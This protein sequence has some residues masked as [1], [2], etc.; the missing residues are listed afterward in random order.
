MSERERQWL[1]AA[2]KFAAEMDPSLTLAAARARITT[3][4]A[5]AAVIRFPADAPVIC[6]TDGL[7]ADEITPRLSKAID[8]VRAADHCAIALGITLPVGSVD[9][10]PLPTLLS[11]PGSLVVLHDQRPGADAD[12]E[13]ESLARFAEYAA[14]ALDRADAVRERE[15]LAVVSERN[16]IARDL[17]DVVIQRLFAVG[18]MLDAARGP[19]EDQRLEKV[20]TE[21]DRTIADIRT[22]IFELGQSPF[23]EPA[24]MPAA[25]SPAA[26]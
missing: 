26:R 6:A 17:H 3:A 10:V 11:P 20:V 8:Q 2:A 9:V 23:S 15:E 16:R 13:R 7:S 5:A 18:L 14:L 21:L 25:Q 4:A 19:G 12:E 24:G 22:T 1:H